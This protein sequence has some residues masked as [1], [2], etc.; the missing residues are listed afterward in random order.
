MYIPFKQ[1]IKH[2][3]PSAFEVARDVKDQIVIEFSTL[4]QVGIFNILKRFV[5]AKEQWRKE[6]PLQDILR[7][8]ITINSLEELKANYSNAEG[9]H[10]YYFSPTIVNNS[11]LKSIWDFL[12]SDA[13]IKIVKNIGGKH[14]PFAQL[15]NTGRAYL[16]SSPSHKDLI[17]VHN[18]FYNLGIGPRLYNV[19]EIAFA[20]GDVHVAYIMQHIAGHVCN[21][22]VQADNFIKQIKALE[23]KKLIKLINWNGY[24]DMD[25][26]SPNCNGNLISMDDKLYY[27]DLQNFA[28]GDYNSYLQ[29][30]AI[31][32]SQFSHFG[33]KSF[34]MGGKYLYQEIPG[35]NLPAKR[36]PA[37]RYEVFSKLIQQ[38][39]I[40]LTNKL[41]IDIG[42]NMGLMGAQYLK[43]GAGWLHGFDMPE[44]IKETN[45][46]LLSIGCTRFSTTGLTLGQD[47]SLIKHLPIHLNDKLSGCIISYLA[48]RGHIGWINE[49]AN[50]QW[51]YMLYEGHQ[52]EDEIMSLNYIKNLQELKACRIVCSGWVDDANSTKRYIAILK[53]E[54]AKA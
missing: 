24:N 54:P 11:P 18:L 37:K 10:T 3:F 16:L 39:G 17:L 31:N 27:I 20:N 30:I 5:K 32:A 33:Q 50:I 48:I 7:T 44:V 2:T 53:A 22:K 38:A 46:V 36:S 6:L 4:R 51:E 42:C 15:D 49:L 35:S 13:G 28:L 14:K 23:D 43:D 12:P 41:I 40:S 29:K 25:F 47:V 45:K 19:V 34:L 1:N 52:E 9:G 26:K 8:T 21:D